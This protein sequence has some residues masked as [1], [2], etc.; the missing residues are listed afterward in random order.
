MHTNHHQPKVGQLIL[1]VSLG[2]LV[3]LYDLLLFSSVRTVSLK[4]LHITGDLATAYTTSLLNWTVYGMVFGGFLWGIL[5]DRLGRLNVLFFSILTYSIANILNAFVYDIDHYHWLRFFSGLG[6]AGELGVGITLVSE[7]LPRDKR[8]KAGMWI[9]GFGMIGAVL[10]GSL[11]Y[12]FK[13]EIII[14]L[15]GWRFLFLMGGIMGLLLLLMRLINK[16]ESRLFLQ[17]ESSLRNNLR[18]LFTPKVSIK[19]I[20]CVLAG[21][22]VFFII[23][24]F[25]TLSPEY[26]KIQGLENINPALSVVFC[27]LGVCGADFL[28]NWWSK[29]IKSRKKI[30][31]YFL[32]FQIISITLY[33]YFPSFNATVFYIKTALLG[34]SAGYWGVLI[35]NGLEQFGTNLRSTVATSVPNMIRGALI[36]LTWLFAQFRA[37]VDLT[38]SGAIVAGIAIITAFICV[39]FLKETFEN[40]LSF[41]EE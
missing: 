28:A 4:E 34:I 9:T 30:L 22:P 13:D 23:G 2:Y 19:Y 33:L 6:L 12:W 29:Q 38:T 24:N 21:F 35:L 20:C 1:A 7:L 32:G 25:I 40:D 18:P 16:Q 37:Y 8:T 36:P 5:A 14:G 3:D 39:Y 26:G 15:S 31:Y 11:A 27:Y 41:K 10:A 17:Y